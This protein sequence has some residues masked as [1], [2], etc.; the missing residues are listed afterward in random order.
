MAELGCGVVTLSVSLVGSHQWGNFGS[1]LCSVSSFVI[2]QDIVAANTT[3]NYCTVHKPR[4]VTL[5]NNA[6]LQADLQRQLENL[7]QSQSCILAAIC[8]LSLLALYKLTNEKY[9]LN[10]F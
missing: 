5:I 7:Y 3:A 2:C 10:M 4:V 1:F 6:C 8:F 9:T